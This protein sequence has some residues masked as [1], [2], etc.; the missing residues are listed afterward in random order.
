MTGA[1]RS[2]PRRTREAWLQ[3]LATLLRPLFKRIA[4]P[5]PA[6]LRISCGWPSK[7]ALA[8]SG[9]NR[10][11]GQCWPP[12][13]SADGTTEVFVSPALS[14]APTV[15]HVLVHELIHASGLMGHAADFRHVALRLGLQGPMTATEAGPE[16]AKRL[17]ALCL[18]IGPY[19]HA[20]LD[21][22]QNPTKKQGTR[23]KKVIC[24]KCDYTVRTTRQWLDIGLP[25][26]PCGTEM[27]EDKP[28]G[29]DDEED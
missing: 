25:V 18:Q 3:K 20:T 2:A 4:Q 7:R 28:E 22:A 14:D 24:P 23:M 17:H 26:C 19:P 10:S 13:A 29:T 9:K 6:K 12:E 1:G 5:L 16:L 21:Q 27:Q 8:A 15:A 11:I